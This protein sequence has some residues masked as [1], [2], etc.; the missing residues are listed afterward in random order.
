LPLPEEVNICGLAPQVKVMP[1]GLR[2]TASEN[3]RKISVVTDTPLAPLAGVLP[4]S[5]GGL[6]TGAPND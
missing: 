2:V 5:C 1:A 4:V 3:C 6:S